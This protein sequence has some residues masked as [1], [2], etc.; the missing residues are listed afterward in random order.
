MIMNLPLA[1]MKIIVCSAFICV[2]C[3]I[4]EAQDS[5]V[6]LKPPTLPISTSIRSIMDQVLKNPSE[7]IKVE[8]R[9]EIANEIISKTH[10]K[11]PVYVEAAAVQ[12]LTEHGCYR[13]GIV[14]TLPNTM[15]E[16]KDGGQGTPLA[17]GQQMNWC[18][19]GLAPSTKE[20]AQP[21]HQRSV[22]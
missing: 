1:Y 2:F 18:I 7:R 16:R 13:I 22:Q 14:F 11:A 20:G 17:F 5:L 10:G 12:Q 19:N 4:C 8:L 9:G 15:L 21:L 3:N 6:R